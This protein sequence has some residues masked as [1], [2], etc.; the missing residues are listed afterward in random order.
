VWEAGKKMNEKP[1]NNGCLYVLITKI[2]CQERNNDGDANWLD[3]L[4]ASHHAF[5]LSNV[6]FMFTGF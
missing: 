3:V 1:G 5:V 4:P 2:G 6:P